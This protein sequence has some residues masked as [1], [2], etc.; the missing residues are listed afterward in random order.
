M[1][2]EINCFYDFRSKLLASNYQVYAVG[3]YDKAALLMG[4][5]ANIKFAIPFKHK[6]GHKMGDVL[7]TGWTGLYLISDKLKDDLP[8]FDGRT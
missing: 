1:R 6:Y 3:K 5:Y 8:R 4:D 2:L 7:D